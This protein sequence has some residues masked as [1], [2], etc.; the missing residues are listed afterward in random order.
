M[1]Q[2]TVAIVL[3]AI[4]ALGLS[5]CSNPDYDPD[6]CDLQQSLAAFSLEVR[7]YVSPSIQES[8]DRYCTR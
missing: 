5:G 2:K 4:A 8:V 7:G 1:T 3:T 6:L